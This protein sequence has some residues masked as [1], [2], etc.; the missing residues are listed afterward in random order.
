M[1]RFREK[2]IPKSNKSLNKSL[3]QSYS[4]KDVESLSDN[5]RQS[6]PSK[7]AAVF[8]RIRRSSAAFRAFSSTTRPPDPIRTPQPEPIQ[9]P[10]PD[11][12]QPPEPEPIQPPQLY[13]KSSLSGAE[14]RVVVYL[15]SLRVVRPTFEACKTVQSILTGFRVNVDERDLSM[16]ASFSS[17]LQRIFGVS[18]ETQVALPRVFIGG[19]Y[20]G[21]AEELRQLNETGELKKMIAELPEADAG[22]CEECGGFKFVVCEECSGSHKCYREKNDGFRTCNVCNE[23]GLIRCNSCS[24]GPIF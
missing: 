8:H 13:P 24:Y 9:T 18:E 15:T 6:A 23:S 22:V 20:I 11:P 5:D 17:E 14:D 16:D 1:W 3:S 7:T 12:I 21:G 10:Q 19:K 4:F 2:I